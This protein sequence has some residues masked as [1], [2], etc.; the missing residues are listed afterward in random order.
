MYRHSEQHRGDLPIVSGPRHCREEKVIEI[1][2]KGKSWKVTRGPEA[3][4][5]FMIMSSV[6]L[7]DEDISMKA[8]GRGIADSS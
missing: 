5:S 4:C 1:I 2:S 3:A 6:S 8:E 7:L